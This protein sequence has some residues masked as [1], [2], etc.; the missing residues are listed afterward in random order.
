MKQVIAYATLALVSLFPIQSL[1]AAGLTGSTVTVGVYTTNPGTL[2]LASNTPS[3]TIGPGVEF[4]L[5][6]FTAVGSFNVIAIAIDL[7]ANT[8]DL[9]YPNGASATATSFN[10]YIFDFA[11]LALPGITGVSVDPLSSLAPVGFSF[12]ANQVRVNVEGLNIPAN[13]DII[14]DIASV[15]AVPEPETYEMMLAGLGLVGFIGRR[16]T[17]KAS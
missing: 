17:R 7:T 10:G 13:R 4:P 5:G 15:D 14:L 8:I 11:N 6:S 12:T 3:A 9:H 16:K 2:T 1:N